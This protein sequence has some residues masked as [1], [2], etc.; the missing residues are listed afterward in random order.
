MMEEN[1]GKVRYEQ[2][3]FESPACIL[4]VYK[5]IKKGVLDTAWTIM[6]QCT[7]SRRL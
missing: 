3:I 5:M 6:A 4:V 1:L 2:A 7:D